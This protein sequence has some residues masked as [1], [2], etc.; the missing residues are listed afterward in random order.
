MQPDR[1]DIVIIGGGNA[2]FG[3]SQIAHPA[4]K[5]IAFVESAEFGGTI[6]M[7]VKGANYI[8]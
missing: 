1:Y 3:V 4:G 5:S 2:G 6:S 8:P 7:E